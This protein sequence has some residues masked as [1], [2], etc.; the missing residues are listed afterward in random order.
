M[1]VGE[2]N[3]NR[4]QCIR[5]L[6]R[7][8]FYLDNKRSGGHDK[9]RPP[10]EMQKSIKFPQPFFIMVPRHNELHCQAEIM[11]ELMCI[12]GEALLDA[13][14]KELIKPSCWFLSLSKS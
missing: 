3:F 2:K 8:G 4:K 10:L 11:A 14:K 6:T 9:Y 12:G 1:H 7:L 5:A 13:F